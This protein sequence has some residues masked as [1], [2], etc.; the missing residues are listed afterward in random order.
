MPTAAP[1]VTADRFS[2]HGASVELICEVP[3]LFGQIEH[4]LG[5][6]RVMGFPQ[7]LAPV[8]GFVR[9]YSEA[10]VLKRLSPT[11]RRVSGAGELLELYEDG[12]RFW[13]VDDRWGIA[14]INLLKAQWRS[15]VLPHAACDA[16]T[17]AR[18]ALL[19]PMAQLLRA[20]GIWL[21]PAASVALGSRGMLILAPFGLE[22]ELQGL[23][24]AGYGVIGQ[25]W[26]AIR[27]QDGR[28][29]LLHLPGHVERPVPPGLRL[30]SGDPA[31]TWVD[32]MSLHAGAERRCG[33]CEA[34]FVVEPGRRPLA[35][36][37]PI[38]PSK[39]LHLLRSA[40]PIAELHP[41][42]RHAQLPAR[43]AQRCATYQLRLSREP[44][45]LLKMLGN[46]PPARGEISLRAAG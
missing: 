23:I 43:L 9:K 15:W 17:C 5:G 1:K 33:F 20:R 22:P 45:D 42:R 40:W 34:V 31:P 13:V 25:S 44:R 26:T 32:L 7:G 27:E 39:S 10:E 29:E 16:V 2:L 38:D 19:W 46:L 35:G 21:I 36:V 14:E 41:S 12:E 11:A 28:I 18:R 24:R 4:L 8:S 3:A 37:R 6:F 30:A